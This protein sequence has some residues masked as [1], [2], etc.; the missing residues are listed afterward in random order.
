MKKFILATLGTVFLC[1]ASGFV[2]WKLAKRKY[3]NSEPT[4]CVQPAEPTK[5]VEPFIKIVPANQSALD[6]LSDRLMR[7]VEGHSACE[8]EFA[9][10]QGR[11][12]KDT[13]TIKPGTS[14]VAGVTSDKVFMKQDNGDPIGYRVGET[15][16]SAG[17]LLSID[18]GSGRA[19]TEQTVLYVLNV[20]KPTR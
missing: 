17:R 9:K 6:D 2:G 4:Q 5:P 14:L 1:S 11:Y 13:A 7:S 8:T 19:V 10:L 18:V 3:A 15:I 12:P 16:P 20:A